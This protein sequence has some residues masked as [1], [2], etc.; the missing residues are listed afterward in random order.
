MRFLTNEEARAWC[1]KR[2]PPFLD[3]RRNP[4]QWPA[5]LQ[6]LRF[7]YTHATPGRLFWLSQRLVAA[8][9]YWETALLWV[10]LTGIWPSSENTHLYY[11]IRQSYGDQRHLDQAPAHLALRHEGE[12]LT[13][14]LHLCMMFGWEA[15]LFTGHDYAR[16]FVSHDEYGEIAVPEGHSLVELHGVLESAGVK[17]EPP[18]SAV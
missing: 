17:V 4:L 14:L 3:E 13:T 6:V 12:D 9:E 1:S 15:F 18:R 16:I 5:R 7:I 8:L 10:V 11:R 2:D